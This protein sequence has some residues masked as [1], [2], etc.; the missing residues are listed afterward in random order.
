MEPTDII[1]SYIQKLEANKATL[2]KI[3]NQKNCYGK[4]LIEITVVDNRAL[5]EGNPY[6]HSEWLHVLVSAN[7]PICSS[8]WNQIVEEVEK[9]IKDNVTPNY[10]CFVP[11]SSA[12]V[13][14]ENRLNAIGEQTG[15]AIYLPGQKRHG[16]RITIEGSSTQQ[17]EAAKR[18]VE[19]LIQ[20]PSCSSERC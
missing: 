20:T 1:D 17:V 8:C 7:H 13:V 6:D 10:V 11:V 5:Q 12:W 16:A 19:Q 4:S 3:A 9:F 14:Q 2:D 18:M 15:A